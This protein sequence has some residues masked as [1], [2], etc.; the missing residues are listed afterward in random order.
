[1]QGAACSH[2]VYPPIYILRELLQQLAQQRIVMPGYTFL[3][4]LVGWTVTVER[5]RIADLLGQALTPE[6][7]K[8][9]E[10]LLRADEGMYR[11]TVLKHE[12][13]DFSYKELRQEVAR[14]QIFR[15]LHEFACAFLA[16]TGLSN[17][18]V[19]YYASLVQ[20]YTVYKLQR[21]GAAT[22]RLYLLCFAYHRFRQIN[23]NLV[24]AFIHLVDHYEQEA[25]LTAREEV[26]HARAEAAQDLIAAGRVLD[27]F[28][29]P[30]IPD[31]ATFTAVKAK[32][33]SLL[34]AERFPAVSAYMRNVEFDQTG[35]EWAYYAKLSATIKRNLRQL[36]TDLTFADRVEDAPLIAAVVFLQNL[37]R[38]GKS[39]RQTKQ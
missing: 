2:V 32:A 35:F 38:Q 23:D 4:D 1:M 5:Q 30:S 14:R 17:E 18:S 11:I 37:L 8:Q 39:P 33:F 20:F 9:L 13:K 21:M 16:T 24:D 31:V 36:F 22:A 28:I 3:Q 12:P 25:K 15:P 6:I 34:G 7:E 10:A 26:Q 27:L 29:D 19:K